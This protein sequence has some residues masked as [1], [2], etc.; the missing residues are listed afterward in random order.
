MFAQQL[1]AST[2]TG[3]LSCGTL[4]NP[5]RR[6]E[7]DGAD[8]HAK[9]S[10]NLATNLALQFSGIGQQFFSL[11][12]AHYHNVFCPKAGIVNAHRNRPAIVNRRMRS[13]DFFDVLWVEVLATANQQILLATDH[14]E[15]AVALKAEV[16][17]AVP[18]IA[19]DFG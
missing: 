19:Q 10:D 3:R 7:E 4:H 2:G 11:H 5:L 16:A 9:S 8:R 12:F 13:D 17:G 14:V 15:F 1:L 6:L 18:A